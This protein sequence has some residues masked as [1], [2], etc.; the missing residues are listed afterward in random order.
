MF[1]EQGTAGFPGNVAHLLD[2]RKAVRVFILSVV[3]AFLALASAATVANAAARSRIELVDGSVITGEVVSLSGGVYTVRSATLGTLRIKASDI[4]V[5]SMRGA[6]DGSYER[7]EGQTFEE[8]T[9]DDA[10]ILSLIHAL[11]NDPD[12]QKLVQDPAITKAVQAGDIGA[13]MGNP[14]FTKLLEKYRAK[15][16][17]KPAR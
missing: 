10:E 5:I 12:M 13:L 16:M 7:A 9:P 15:E 8:Q 2:G 4:L 3:L 17:N 14:E 11:Q 1:D 6:G